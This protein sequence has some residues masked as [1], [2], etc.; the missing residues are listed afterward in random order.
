MFYD[1]LKEAC[2]IKG[3]K[4]TPT[5]IECGGKAGSIAG[6]KKGAFPNSE[7]VMKL[8]KKLNVSTDYLLFGEEENTKEIQIISIFRDLTESGKDEVINY[9]RYTLENP[10]Y[11][12]YT[13]VPKEA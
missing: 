3:K 12:K 13:D 1:N 4:I 2:E 10:K 11:Q 5:V 6:W 9:A 8:A 7:I